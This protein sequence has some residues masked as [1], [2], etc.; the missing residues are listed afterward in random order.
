MY[1]G[2]TVAVVIPAHNE[3][4]LIGTVLDTMPDF[5]D[6]IIVVDDA[7]TDRT[8]EIVASYHMRLAESPRVR[9]SYPQ[10]GRRGSDCH[11]L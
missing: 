7:S 5:V 9:V 4:K 11:R 1:E 6:L 10:S 8:S 3:E 2:K